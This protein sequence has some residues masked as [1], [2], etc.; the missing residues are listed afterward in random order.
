MAAFPDVPTFKELGYDLVGG[1]Y[2][3]VAVPVSTPGELRQRISD[4]VSQI[5]QRPDFVKKMEEGGFVLT[6][7]TVAIVSFRLGGHDVPEEPQLSGGTREFSPETRLGEASLLA[8][9]R[10]QRMIGID[11]L[12]AIAHRQQHRLARIDQLGVPAFLAGARLLLTAR[13]ASR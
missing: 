5:N 9:E 2:R 6:A 1:A 4:I 12:A 8:E 7:S 11:V 3:G 10:D 13:I